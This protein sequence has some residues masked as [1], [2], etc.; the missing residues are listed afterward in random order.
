MRLPSSSPRP[1]RTWKGKERATIVER[2]GSGG[3]EGVVLPLQLLEQ[4]MYQS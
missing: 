4:S 2:E 3:S 1:N